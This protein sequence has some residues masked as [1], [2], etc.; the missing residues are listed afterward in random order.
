MKKLGLW[1]ASLGLIVCT[2]V[3]TAGCKFPMFGGGDS[4]ESSSSATIQEYLELNENAITLEKYGQ[5]ALV[6]TTNVSDDIV[7]TTS[8]ASVAT[9]TDGI[10][11]A[12]SVGTAT[13]TATAGK[14]SATCVVTVTHLSNFPEL[15]VS[16]T[17]VE[18]LEGGD[19][20]FVEAVA[21]Y[22]GEVKDC[23]FTWTTANPSIATVE[24]GKI[25]PVAVG[26]TTITVTTVCM[27]EVLVKE[28][29]VLVKVDEQIQLTKSSMSLSLARINPADILTDSF[30]AKAYLRGEE[31]SDV[32]FT[33]E[34]TDSNVADIAVNGNAVTVTAV[35]EGICFINVYYTSAENGNIH[36]AVEVTVSRAK[37][38]VDDLIEVTY[39]GKDPAVVNVAPFALVGEF[40][41]V[42]FNGELVSEN[43]GT[44]LTSFAQ[45]NKG[46]GAMSIELRT[47]VAVYAAQLSIL[48][49]HVPTVAQGDNRSPMATYDGDV[50][51]IGF[52]EGTTVYTFE[53]ASPDYAY[54]DG[55]YKRSIISAPGTQDYI[56]IEF[57][58]KVDIIGNQGVFHVWG[59]DG[60]PDMG[61]I[62]TT[63]AGKNAITDM[64][65]NAVSDILAGNHYLVRIACEGLKEVQV[66]F[67]S[68][69]N[70]VYFGTVSYEEE[71]EFVMV[72]TQ[73]DDRRVM[74]TYVGAATEVGFSESTGTVYMLETS[75]TL[76]WDNRMIIPVENG[77]QYVK[78]DF[79]LAKAISNF[80]MWPENSAG[81]QGS[82]S[83][84]ADRATTSDA[85]ASRTIF[86]VDA[87]GHKVTSFEAGKVYTV[88]FY[89]T[90][91]ISVHFSSFHEVTT[92]VANIEC[93]EGL[94][95]PEEPIISQ[96]E[97]RNPMPTYE[98]D[99]TAL[100]F[101]EGTVV[102]EVVGAQSNSND[103]KLVAK[104]D[105]TGDVAYAKADIV[106]SSKTSSFGLWITAKSSHL[107]YYTITPTGFTTDGNGDPSRDVFVTDKN[108]ERVTSFEANTVY[109]LYVGLEGR[110]VTIQLTTWAALTMYIANVGCVTEAEAPVE[111]LPPVQG[112]ELSILF[113]G[114]S[115]SDDTETYVVDILLGLGYTNINIG[116]LY[117]GGCSIDTHYDNI[118]KDASAYDF[119]M[120]S[121]NGKKYTEYET[122]TVGGEQRSIAYAIAY[123]DWDIISVQQASGE[124]GIASSYKNLDA[125]VSEVKKQ[126][127]NSDVEIVFNMTWAYQGDSTHPQFPDYNNDQMTMYN[128][129][130]SAVQAKVGYTVV[131]NGTAIQNARTSLLGD[132]L[133]RD[134]YHLDLKIG[135]FIAGL[136]FVAKVTGE[137][138]TDLEYRPG[139]INDLQFEIALESVLNA[140]ENPFEVT[141]SEVTEEMFADPDVT[142]G[143]SNATAVTTYK[144]DVT[145]LGFAEG[146]RVYEYVGVDSSSDKASIK[147]DSSQYDYV[148]VDLVIAKGSGYFFMHGLSKGNW[149]NSGTSYVVD[150]GWIRLGDGNNTAS[151]RV[152]E[153]YDANGNKVTSLMKNN[154]VYTLRVYIK[155]GNLDEIRISM[156]G[157]T[158]Y[159]A[160]VKQG[161]DNGSEPDDT[162]PDTNPVVDSNGNALP[163]YKG[164]VTA[165]G[166]VAGAT[167]Y[168]SVQD[169][170]TDNW[171]AGTQL[172]LTMEQQAI[173]I[174]KSLDEDYVSVY[175]SLSRDLTN[176]NYAFFAWWYDASGANKGAAGYLKADGKY[177]V[178]AAELTDLK[179][180]AYDMDGNVATSFVANTVYEMRWYSKSATAF[181]I[182]CCEKNGQSITVYYAD[183]SSGNDEVVEPDGPVNPDAPYLEQGDDRTKLYAYGGDVTA[184]GFAAGTTVYKMVHNTSDNY[185]YGWGKRVMIPAPATQDYITIE[186][187]LTNTITGNNPVFHA[188]GPQGDPSITHIWTS[189]TEKAVITK[190]DG[191][192]ITELLAGT[193]Y[194]L[195]IA[196]KDMDEVQV[197]LISIGNTAYIA[198][199]SY[200]NGKLGAV[201]ISTT[202]TYSKDGNHTGEA[203]AIYAGDVT[204][205]GFAEGATV[206][207]QVIA[208]GW[209][210]RVAIAVDN[211]YDY[212]D[213]Q[214]V[215][216]DDTTLCVWLND[217]PLSMLQGNHT[218][219]MS[220][221]AVAQN[222]AAARK[223][224]ILDENG[225]VVTAMETNTVY[226]LRVYVEGLVQVQLSTWSGARTIYYGEVSFGNEVVS[227]ER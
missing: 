136:T 173:K 184:L 40:E 220:C 188:W 165:L 222:G 107:G 143:G 90:D 14:V 80:T 19:A 148:E 16:E 133:T 180:V 78:F 175:F 116:N 141:E 161:N 122:G 64:E 7:W 30:S 166:F 92:Y 70:T 130:V 94:V 55:W 200:N 174:K 179:V 189:T 42:Y 76:G 149:H 121:H 46:Q 57:T 28:I 201:K 123:K 73:G 11:S 162:T 72:V 135:R 96:G 4:I 50:T 71:G 164:D 202:P 225:N 13:I 185:G 108:G 60:V 63:T 196:C 38:V 75:G 197:G 49:P 111:P 105:S 163:L 150:P 93:G 22:M 34:T 113:I 74:P 89:L 104:I 125:L 98:G 31:K 215:L 58:V 27:G 210:D 61:A 138:I 37:S 110:E 103:V 100:G 20:L 24:N 209:D 101:E 115:F 186:F 112:K 26:E 91:E 159:F 95:T 140:L 219:N 218:I 181:K 102:Y 43:D 65:G 54:T 182:G 36:S 12:V 127:T 3:A 82:Y 25:T 168:E 199:V 190:M 134:G 59:E 142:A 194:L 106:F 23:E 177:E 227:D 8:D 213:I 154:V 155:V 51:E 195:H 124:S 9:V 145:A 214:F 178:R 217:A 198:N 52:E 44:L 1:L 131:P 6:V 83:L 204:A 77:K 109:T 221:E 67:I 139:G 97:A 137:D 69:N 157:S 118:K 160:N 146:T 226:T 120:R 87:S 48:A 208:N 192:M 211:S 171:S 39:N 45:N 53:N 47:D 126:A 132:T 193:H 33:Y 86:V 223:M 114:N 56:T 62:W 66:G 170:R 29:P 32:T 206:Y 147:V 119:R 84:Y 224:Q 151:D 183:P 99:V 17:L 187:V 88:Y 172:G 35:G 21:S 2:S 10:V 212:V 81:T 85:D 176:P 216:T 41:G 169:N 68:V 207:E 144:G 203:A 18:L 158:I 5:R 191:S 117:I 152:I 128:A 129:I 167:V 205:L 153:V 79:V 156:S 15:T